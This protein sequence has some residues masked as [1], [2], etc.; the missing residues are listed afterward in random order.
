[1]ATLIPR[2]QIEEQEDVSG[3]FRIGGDLNVGQD[4][5]ISGSLFVDSN[6]FL[7]DD[8]TDRGELTGSIF[9]TG[10]LT[11]D[12]EF[13]ADEAVNTQKYAGILA[14]DF[15]ANVPTLY[16][17]STDGDDNNDG[18]T[19]QFPLRTIK[20]AA[21]LAQPG[22]DGRYGFDTGSL[23]NGYVIKVQAG[24]YLE[25]NPVIL[26]SNTSIWGAG[27]RITKINAKNSEED[28]FYVNS[29]C[30][31]AE[32]T[33]GGLRLYPNEE[34]PER[35][36]AFAFQPG[37]F[38]TTS[39]YI[40]N[41]TQISNQE[42][43]FTELYEDIPPGGGGLYVNGDAVSPDSPLASMVL[44]A[45]T[46]V[47]PN[48]VG[49]LVNGR[50]FIQLVSFFN[51]FSYYAI[52]VNNGGHATLN[53]SNISFGKF[54]MF[55]SGS[56][57]ISGSGGDLVSRDRIRESYSIIIDVLNKGLDDGLPE[58]VVLNTEEGIRVTDPITHPQFFTSEN[59]GQD[60]ANEVRSDFR[61]VS[62][63][64]EN[65]P[66]NFPTLLAKSG[67]RGYTIDSPFNISGQG[68]ITSSISAST[69]DLTSI[70]SSFSTLLGVFED[71]TGSF[72]LK[73]NTVDT[74]KV[75]DLNTVLASNP[76]TDLITGSVSSS[77][78][79]VSKIL[80]LG[81]GSVPPLIP[82]TDST[83]KV[84]NL[85]PILK[86]FVTSNNVRETV[87]GSFSIVYNLLANGTGS[88]ILDIPIDHQREF[89]VTKNEDS[90]AYVFDGDLENPTITLFRGEEYKFFVS[91]S[92]GPEGQ[93]FFIRRV[94]QS[95]FDLTGGINYNDGVINNGDSIGTITFNVPFN[96]P[97]KLY[98]VSQ[99]SPD[100]IG[101]FMVV[102]SSATPQELIKDSLTWP[103]LIQSSSTPNPGIDFVN[104]FD[105][106]LLNKD[107]I[108]EETVEYLS[109]AWSDFD[110]DKT[111]F[112][113]DI[114][115]IIDGVAKDLKFG[116]NEE[117]IRSGFTYYEFP[118]SAVGEELQPTLTALQY[119]SRLT[120]NLLINSQ[121]VE[122]DVAKEDITDTIIQNKDFV[123]AETI[124]YLSSSWTE[125]EYNEVSFSR[126]I[127]FILDSVA[128]DL[129]YGGNERSI[130]SG[131][132]YYKFPSE[133]TGSQI[134][135]TLD[136]INY[137]A[138][139]TLN[140][141][142][143]KEFQTASLS[144]QESY[145]LI[146]SN[147]GFIQDET[148]EFINATFPSLT[149]DQAKFRGDIGIAV[150]SVSTD[151]LYGGNQRGVKAGRLYYDIPSQAIGRQKRENRAGIQYSR[152]LTEFIVQ[153]I[154]L[155]TPR[156]E[157][158]DERFIK[159]TELN[160]I[161]SSVSGTDTES[162][163]ISQSFAIV[164]DIVRNSPSSIDFPI[165]GNTDSNIK[166]TD[167][168]QTVTALVVDE[169][170]I[171][172]ISQSFSIISETIAEPSFQ[173]ELVK[174]VEGLIKVTQ[175][176]Q[177]TSSISATDEDTDFVTSSFG[178]IRDIIFDGP[179]SV[180]F[181][182]VKNFD[183]GIGDVVWN[184]TD[185]VQSFGG[186]TF[187][188]TSQT[189]FISGSYSTII[190]IVSGGLDAKPEVETNASGGIRV[191]ETPQ[192][193]SPISAG[194]DEINIVSDRFSTVLSIVE[195]GV[196]VIPTLVPNTVKSIK[197]TET[198]NIISGSGGGR[199]QSRIV[200]SS[201]GLIIDIL[202][203]EGTS[204]ILLQEPQPTPNENPRMVSAHNLL[205][206]NTNFI[207]D[208]TIAF[209]SS[210]WSEFEYTQTS[211]EQ[212]LQ[213]I[214]SG[215]AFDLLFGGNS[216][217]FEN[218]LNYF[219]NPTTG[220]I[221]ETDQVSTALRYAAGLATKV[222]VNTNFEHISSS[223]L[224]E[225]SSS[226]HLLKENRKFIQDEAIEYVSSS[227]RG[228]EYNE[229]SCSR[230]VGFII[231]AVRTDLL[232]GGNERS[233]IAGDY[234]YRF[235]SQATTTQLQPT[236]DGI[237]HAKNT[238][239]NV[240]TNLVYQTASVDTQYSYN[241]LIDNKLFIQ[242]ESVA[243][244]NAKYP[245]L[246]YNE[247]KCIRDVGFLVDAVSTDLL[248]GGNQRS[249]KA[250]EFYFL[251]PSLA[252]TD[253]QLN[254]TIGAIKYSSLLSQEVVNDTFIPVPQP[255]SGSV[256]S[257]DP[258]AI[259]TYNLLLD[260]IPFIQA[261]TISYISSSWSQFT[262]N[263][264]SSSKD[265][266]VFVESVANDF[267]SGSNQNS[268]SAS[269]LYTPDPSVDIG[270][271]LD[272][273]ATT[274]EYAGNLAGKLI[275][276]LLFQFPSE[277]NIN[278]QIILQENRDFIQDE[279]MAYLTA[280]WSTFD[281]DKDKCRRDVGF[282]L[283]AVITDTL[284][285]GNE[286]SIIA[287]DYYYR[288]P[289]EA[290][291][292]QLFQ[293]VDGINYASRISQKVV[294]NIEF[295]SASMEVSASFDLLRKNKEFIQR[296]TIEYVSS[297]WSTVF[298]NEESC[299]RDVGFIID[300]AATDLLYGGNERS[301]VAGSFYYLFPSRATNAGVPSEQNQLDPTIT[302]IRYAGR[303]SSRV[304]QNPEYRLP[305]ASAFVGR[306]LLVNNK[307]L[308]Q[309]ETILFLSSSWS[310]FEYNEVSCSRDVGFIIDAVAT[311]LV[312]GGNERS[313]EAGTIY[314][315][316]PSVAIK[317]TISDKKGQKAQT[318]DGINFAGGISE[319]I[320]NKQQL[321]TPGTRRR[322]AAT[323]LF[324]SK[325]ELKQRA[326]SYTNGAFPELI[327]NEASCSR[328]TGFIVDALVTDL[329]YGGNE[330]GV[331]AASSYFTGQ[332]GNADEVIFKQRTETLETN[333]YIR[334][335]AEF[336]VANA[337][338]EEFGSLIVAT[339]IDFSYNGAGVTFKALPP[340]Q[341]GSGIPDPNLEITE[342]GGGRIFFTSGNETGDFRIGTGLTINQATGTLVGRTFSRSLFSLVTPFSLAL[343][344]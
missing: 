239:L 74:I 192:V 115:S 254:E 10:S 210:S 1:M 19:I 344:G 281:Y 229:V 37:A 174:N 13:I 313:I 290:N 277:S 35:G 190:N 6:F 341:G 20:R 201:F 140:V 230:D 208:E 168:P 202:L 92:L 77:F 30:Y 103:P 44:D 279:T 266:E 111:L 304:I 309:K 5:V 17:S 286:R 297:S 125:F 243:F 133:A 102:N 93:P 330:R 216:A 185:K 151:L 276:N 113:S 132:F 8:L 64:V 152:T 261:E 66:N 278:S 336:I 184:I 95:G 189:E 101:E 112:K 274:I 124:A 263:Q 31:V 158:N 311:D 175:A 71:G 300:A 315:R 182:L 120:D 268:I 298:Y 323:R 222:V 227:W 148:I 22:Y 233:I 45:Y 47:S 339:G 55:A 43:S 317:D 272:V 57:L 245:N 48:G 211:F 138:G 258:I 191:T 121:F 76:A 186:G 90:T 236:L 145:N 324:N 325:D 228:F 206:D 170:E 11:I 150:D 56:R 240:I 34:E 46:Q 303:L 177:I 285:G 287:G 337:P 238:S 123:K 128:T 9:I 135:Q 159:V 252:I 232:Y 246:R 193:T 83:I 72:E 196:G 100:M 334:T 326:I 195:E 332:F 306:E 65:G 70:S 15:G 275:Q 91:T 23:F 294:Q 318:V 85:E 217:S 142:Q 163:L 244:V 183:Y 116:G 242:S 296:E 68:Q 207:V 119:I 144:T 81:T 171:T 329:I 265:I 314:Y 199:L 234:Y 99:D 98:Y 2:K 283:D 96:A 343:E 181:S 73:K 157:N 220:T 160:N 342:L 289:S 166:V 26:P 38:I 87:S 110:Y 178:L 307:E 231:D 248:Y 267:I 106:L 316:I 139:T 328:D 136:G 75:T 226:V 41:C 60:R 153:N 69:D 129:L 54:G 264:E 200:S 205:L 29:G 167:T 49:C 295:V 118:T 12:G 235:P 312:Y 340:N 127:G 88:P 327:Y 213:L 156:I 218:G 42:N 146:Q 52:R 149:Y 197:V 255:L 333:R 24:T 58:T 215:A 16:V 270:T 36:F 105:T 204:S 53:N 79:I 282:I 256:A 59:A 179:N 187:D 250:G 203:N 33:V 260:N 40:Q 310:T 212:D 224:Q 117:S 221:I 223:V 301:V 320:V 209:M 147:R 247:S 198:P 271:Q 130:E 137:A 104:A 262:Y 194:E 251:F 161:T 335:R 176:P 293:T 18:R 241:Q 94:P 273:T 4:A 253:S 164:Q 302:G 63:I 25:D 84:S 62:Q 141:I 249:V 237:T 280:S 51:N 122:P 288:F 299:S 89:T 143:N 39:P 134:I 82:N 321:L 292:S 173:P 259:S 126:D 7:G 32:V 257:T 308:I 165:I 97:D 331:T 154:I 80:E 28:L 225:L 114:S 269:V 214:I 27:L 78:S 21:Q 131:I 109:Y 291:K 50:G 162:A 284:Y 188:L 14:R 338:L 180:P 108:V 155:E 67:N 169:T 3:S 319:K 305:S 107:F 86:G 219:N 322:D 172:K 61:L